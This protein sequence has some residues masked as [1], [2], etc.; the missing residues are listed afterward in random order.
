MEDLKNGRVVIPTPRWFIGLR[1]VQIII[2]LAIVALAGAFIHGYYADPLGVAIASGIFTWVV[3]LYAI[4]TEHNAGCRSGYNTWALLSLDF[5]LAILWLASLGSNAAFR[6]TFTQPVSVS[7]CS[8]DGSAV[9][10]VTCSV[11]RKRSAVATR[12]GLNWLSS[13]AGLSALMFIL[14]IATF[15]YVAHFFRME[16]IRQGGGD[17]EKA[18]PAAAPAAGVVAASQPTGHVDQAQPFLNN[19][20]AYPQ[21][22]Q[23]DQQQMY[24]QQQ[25]Y[26]QTQ[27][28][29]QWVQPQQ[30]GYPPAQNVPYD[31][32]A[33]YNTN[34][35]TYDASAQGDYDHYYQPRH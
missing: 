12:E 17:A 20:T 21:Q 5:F 15:S 18:A 13:V 25:Q 23:H 11:Y 31:Q 8:S 4:L 1:V 2:S 6:S 34:T 24:Q 30:T 29:Q 14:F 26:Q 9:N 22:Q 27:E 28:Q 33:Q 19:N 7:G 10:A 3:A 32:N 16:W 35:T